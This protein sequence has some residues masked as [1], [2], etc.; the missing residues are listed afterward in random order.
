MKYR[1]RP[2]TTVDVDGEMKTGEFDS[3]KKTQRIKTLLG[4][5]IIEEI[6]DGTT[7]K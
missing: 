7:D 4:K 2:G 1:V 6:K 5:K 3:A